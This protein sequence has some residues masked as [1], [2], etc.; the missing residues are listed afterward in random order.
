MKDVAIK[1]R[2]WNP[3]GSTEKCLKEYKL[4]QFSQDQGEFNW[5]EVIGEASK[6][7][8]TKLTTPL[9]R[10]CEG[11]RLLEEH[12]KEGK[13]PFIFLICLM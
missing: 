13:I 6:V 4:I 7:P 12:S 9:K 8:S 11:K 3:V 10:F 5:I 1:E 2:W